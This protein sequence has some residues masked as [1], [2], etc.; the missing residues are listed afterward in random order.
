MVVPP[1]FVKVYRQK[2]WISIQS[3]ELVPG[4]LISL[5]RGSS[6]F[7]CP[8]D[9]LLLSGSCVVNE[10]MLTGESTPRLK[11]CKFDFISKKIYI[12]EK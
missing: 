2:K 6:E 3:Y 9:I 10:A 1:T 5:G 4:D 8:A 12:F 11:V 7:V